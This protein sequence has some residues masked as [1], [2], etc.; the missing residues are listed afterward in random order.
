M[1]LDLTNTHTHR[2]KATIKICI[3]S[4]TFSLL[5]L[6]PFCLKRVSVCE[7]DFLIKLSTHVCV[8]AGVGVVGGSPRHFGVNF[9]GRAKG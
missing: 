8:C 4:L 9:V 1:R 6:L 7:E 2:Y 5:R 3:S